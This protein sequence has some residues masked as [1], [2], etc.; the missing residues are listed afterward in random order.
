MESLGYAE[1]AIK[2]EDVERSARFYIDVV[3]YEDSQ[4]EFDPDH[5][6]LKVGPD[7][8]LGL[9]KLGALPKRT[10]M[11]GRYGHY[12]QRNIGQVHLVFAIAQHEVQGLADRLTE[13][14]YEI[15]GPETHDDSGELH[16]YASDPDGHAMEWW[17][18]LA[19]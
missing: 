1:V 7:H 14:G 8:Y 9:H 15:H 2:V 3:G 19:G 13:A 5:R 4:Y 16:L 10:I 12:H 17:G 11:E 6:I 18:K